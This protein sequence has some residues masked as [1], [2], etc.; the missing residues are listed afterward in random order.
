MNALLHRDYEV[1]L[2]SLQ[3]YFEY[4]M[5]HAVVTDTHAA[6]HAQASATGTSP[7]ELNDG[8]HGAS[9]GGPRQW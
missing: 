3:R 6:D 8:D 7:R 5:V 9:D 2:D 1:A 4:W